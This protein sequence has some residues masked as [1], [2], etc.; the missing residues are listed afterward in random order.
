MS[1]KTEPEPSLRPPEAMAVG[2]EALTMEVYTDFASCGLAQAWDAFVERVSGDIFLTFDWQRIWWKYYGRG[3]SL[4]VY[5]FRVGEEWVGL[6]PMFTETVRLG[7]L[8]VRRA[9]MVGSDYSFGHFRPAIVTDC[10]G[11]V[12]GAMLEDLRRLGCDQVLLGP[13][14]GRYEYGETLREAL[15]KMI[16]AKFTCRQLRYPQ[17]YYKLADDYEQWL[18]GL[19]TSHRKSVRKEYRRLENQTISFTIEFAGE[20]RLEEMFDEFV[21]LHQQNW[22]EQ[23]KLGHFG[24]WPHSAAFHSELARAQIKKERLRLMRIG[25][26]D[27]S[28]GYAYNYRCGDMYYE[29][30]SARTFDSPEGVSMGRVIHAETVKRCAIESVKWIDSMQG[31]YDHKSELEGRCLPQR[32]LVLEGRGAGRRIRIGL[33]RLAA[34]LVHLL[35]YKLY[36]C[37]LA[38]HL[39]TRR[40]RGLREGWIRA[41]GELRGTVKAEHFDSTDAE[42][43]EE[44]EGKRGN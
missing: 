39:S 27:G 42:D 17:T 44:K 22:N 2:A 13:L 30:L 35:Y 25:F 4:R 19:K 12:L 36:F 28:C 38:T 1:S 31:R 29:Y 43:E 16:G 14:A 3:R 9:K 20:E 11:P 40:R 23:G 41:C 26:S 37:R 15:S 6:V 32:L 21:R 8:W 24:D 18:R 5:I 10:L 34:E 7:P 33:F